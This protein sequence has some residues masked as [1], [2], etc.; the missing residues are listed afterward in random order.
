[1]ETHEVVMITRLT[2]NLTLHQHVLDP[3]TRTKSS[4]QIMHV[5]ERTEIQSPTITF[6]QLEDVVEMRSFHSGEAE[7]VE[8]ADGDSGKC[9]LVDVLDS[10]LG[11]ERIAEVLCRALVEFL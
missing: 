7:I 9:L 6:P 1:M 8:I 3:V 10:V 4:S 11:C 5:G 2:H